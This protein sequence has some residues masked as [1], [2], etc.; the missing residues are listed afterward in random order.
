[1]ERGKVGKIYTNRLRIVKNRLLI[2]V[3]IEVLKY[4][5]TFGNWYYSPALPRNRQ[6]R[7]LG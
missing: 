4:R 7:L 6:H 3:T 2:S 5:I 1:V